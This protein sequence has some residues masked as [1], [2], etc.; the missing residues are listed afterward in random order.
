MYERAVSTILFYPGPGAQVTFIQSLLAL[1]GVIALALGTSVYNDG[2]RDVPSTMPLNTQL[3]VQA[4]GWRNQRNLYLTC[5]A[6]ALWWS[7]YATFAYKARI[8]RLL[9]KIDDLE[10]AGNSSS[11]AVNNKAEASSVRQRLPNPSAPAQE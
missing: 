10:Q 4:K 6:L 7:V 3:M 9:K 1:L 8:A 2:Q 5:L 11:S